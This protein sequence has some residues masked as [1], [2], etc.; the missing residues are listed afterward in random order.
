MGLENEGWGPQ[1][2]PGALKKHKQTPT[3]THTHTL[4][5]LPPT[6]NRGKGGKLQDDK[7]TA[8]EGN[9][10]NWEQSEWG[11]RRYGAERRNNKQT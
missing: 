1:G 2:G 9:Q 11:S 5:P 4:P 8:V 7:C 3:H 10:T 6:K